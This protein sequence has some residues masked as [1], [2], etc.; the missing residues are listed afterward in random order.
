V[1][2][3]ASQ[4]HVQVAAREHITLLC[5]GAYIRIAGGNIELGMPGTFT[6]KAGRHQFLGSAQC[7]TP[8]LEFPDATTSPLRRT[9]RFSL[10]ALPEH[11]TSN[12]AEE[13]Y[14]L[15][16]DGVLLQ[17]GILDEHGRLQWQHQEGT[18]TYRLQLVTGQAFEIDARQRFSDDETERRLQMLSNQGYRS[19]T[20]ED[21]QAIP[22][23]AE[24]EGFR[25]LQV[26]WLRL[27]KGK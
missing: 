18:K 20:P 17:A 6:V 21:G 24:G 15:F 11:L 5:G 9:M 22:G 10:G 8:L 25:S 3:S 19:H 27:A 16:A 13:P 2:I 14:Q 12:Y 23:D 1:E 7:K 26:D 4:Q